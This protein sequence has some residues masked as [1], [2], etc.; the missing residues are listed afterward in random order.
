MI[1]IYNLVTKVVN[2]SKT[3]KIYVVSGTIIVSCLAGL[4][5]KCS[6]NAELKA[7]VEHM[8]GIR[9]VKEGIKD[10]KDL[11]KDIKAP[12]LEDIEKK[13]EAVNNDARDNTSITF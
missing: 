8:E 5:S 6:E 2:A 11:T 3:T 4:V 9:Q 1:E 13:N 10:I 7:R 12:T